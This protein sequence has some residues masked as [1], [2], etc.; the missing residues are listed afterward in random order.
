MNTLVNIHLMQ[1]CCIDHISWAVPNKLVGG[2][3]FKDA[4]LL[5]CV[6]QQQVESVT[7]QVLIIK[8]ISNNSTCTV[9]FYLRSY[10]GMLTCI[11]VAKV[12]SN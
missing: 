5:L 3:G 10:A 7:H 9:N 6:L 2:P 1:G 11:Q 12:H 8:S 4:N